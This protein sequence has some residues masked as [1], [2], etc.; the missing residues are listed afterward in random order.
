MK[1]RLGQNVKRTPSWNFKGGYNEAN[2][3]KLSGY[4][5]YIHPKGR[6]YMVEFQLPSGVL[7]EC[8]FDREG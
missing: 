2:T 4:V 6:Y 5:R 1:V 3:P 8:Y 7:R